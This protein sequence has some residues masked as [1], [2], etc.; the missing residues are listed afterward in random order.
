MNYAK[1]ESTAKVDS[2]MK[3]W[4]REAIKVLTECVTAN[5]DSA[6]EHKPAP[7]S[8]PVLN[9]GDKRGFLRA[10]W[11][12]F[13]PDITWQTQKRVRRGT[14]QIYLDVSG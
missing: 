13:L 2:P 6:F 10:K 7:M 12:P 14:T 9:E 5:K 4:E 8:L 11:S 1:T 3:I